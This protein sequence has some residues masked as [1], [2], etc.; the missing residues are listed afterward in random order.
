MEHPAALEDK[1]RQGE[2]RA[3]PIAREVL[4]R[5]RKKLGFA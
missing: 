4:G 3:R 1:L 5:V 2:D